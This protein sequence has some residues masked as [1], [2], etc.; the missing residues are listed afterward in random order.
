MPETPK[1]KFTWKDGIYVILFII[2]AMGYWDING[3]VAEQALQADQ[4]E[5]NTVTLETYN[6]PVLSYK[7]DDMIGK[8]DKL[9]ILLEDHMR[10]S[11]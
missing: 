8:I 5:R 2:A 9:T 6:L 10:V 4:V 1:P 7:M 11:P 3:K